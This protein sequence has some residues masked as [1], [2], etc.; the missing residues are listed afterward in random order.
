MNIVVA[1][2]AFLVVAVVLW[3]IGEVNYKGFEYTEDVP[4]HPDPTAHQG[5]E[6]IEMGLR[7][8]LRDN[9]TKGYDAVG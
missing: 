3:A 7:D 8:I 1:F 9:S 4:H 2:I 6:Y 5:G